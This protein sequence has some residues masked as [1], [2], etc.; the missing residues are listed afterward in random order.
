MHHTA[1][2]LGLTF[3]V[4]TIWRTLIAGVVVLGLGLYRRAQGDLRCPGQ[5]AADL[6][7][8]RQLDQPAGAGT[9]SASRTA[10]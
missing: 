5:A 2:W 8:R 1:Q 9:T 10:T 4:D 6:G 3:N 7:E